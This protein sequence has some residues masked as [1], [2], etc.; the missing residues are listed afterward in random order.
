VFRASLVAADGILN[1]DFDRSA[2][3]I[4]ETRRLL[5]GM[6]RIE[7]EPELP[8]IGDSLTLLRTALGAE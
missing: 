2:Q 8:R 4:I 1:R 6:M 3:D 7:V 5:A